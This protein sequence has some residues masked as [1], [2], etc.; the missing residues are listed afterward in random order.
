MT[1]PMGIQI[2]KGRGAT[3]EEIAHKAA[4][5]II[6]VADRMDLNDQVKDE[7]RAFQKRIETLLVS[8]AR[9]AAFN[10]RVSVYNMVKD[11]GHPD[12]AKAIMR[13]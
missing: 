13:K 1:R 9:E 2:N 6:N 8:V 10:D 3:P 5:K 11:A 7:A 4:R 12:L